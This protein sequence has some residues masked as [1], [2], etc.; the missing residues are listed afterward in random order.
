MY[1]KPTVIS[2]RL[3]Y[4]I[5]SLGGQ[6]ENGN[7]PQRAAVEALNA[8]LK[9][10]EKCFVNENL[11]PYQITA[12]A[13]P[14]EAM[15][16]LGDDA[17]LCDQASDGRR[18]FLTIIDP[19]NPQ[20]H[21][22]RNIARAFDEEALTA[23]FSD[24]EFGSLPSVQTLLAQ[25]QHASA[26]Q[27]FFKDILLTEVR[28]DIAD[29]L[30]DEPHEE[31][32]DLSG[33]R[34]GEHYVKEFEGVDP[35]ESILLGERYALQDA[36]NERSV[37]AEM[38]S[39]SYYEE[40]ALK[41][42]ES[43]VEDLM[44][45]L[46][47]LGV[48]DLDEVMDG[49]RE[50]AQDTLSNR[51]GSVYYE[52]QGQCAVNLIPKIPVGTKGEAEGVF[53]EHTGFTSSFDNQV[54]DDHY[55]AMLDILRMD[56][57]EWIEYVST[58]SLGVS[59]LNWD[60]DLKLAIDAHAANAREHQ[61][62]L[63]WEGA[64]AKQLQAALRMQL[65]ANNPELLAGISLDSDDELTPAQA[66]AVDF[67]SDMAMQVLGQVA[68]ELDTQWLLDNGVDLQALAS[69]TST[70]QQQE[71]F[72]QLANWPRYRNAVD[73]CCEQEASAYEWKN[74]PHKAAPD[75]PLLTNSKLMELLDNA[76]YGG[77]LVIS[78]KA[79]IDTLHKMRE[80]MDSEQ[81]GK[82]IISDAYV[83][84][85]TFYNGAGD[86]TDCINDVELDAHD[87]KK[88]WV[89]QNDSQ[90]VYGIQATFGQLLA[91][92]SDV[93]VKPTPVPQQA[94]APKE[95]ACEGAQLGM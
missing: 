50:F 45:A 26:L 76:S 40:E 58:Q 46:Q 65:F 48:G 16:S 35:V 49:L 4:D 15:Q 60:I 78:F 12:F 1:H 5:Q 20:A 95:P 9:E 81:G 54:L 70:R 68:D 69:M 61:H 22:A 79:D 74:P 53:V 27:D 94:L 29:D 66:N 52:P 62:G 14:E 64:N 75:K 19:D 84:L 17:K 13:T 86:G 8:V 21:T 83:H 11:T 23:F 43:D 67:C 37:D 85:H 56:V 41:R 30:P 18:V 72:P 25:M 7:A 47:V 91:S 59:S 51:G 2:A 3:P 88:N 36:I 55:Y 73:A 24:A 63:V 44:P 38:E 82:I 87:L 28:Q 10:F 31:S 89:I 77:E 39:N 57:K 32:Y 34:R 93:T 71:A 42:V 92:S 80:C 6:I 90:R 33:G